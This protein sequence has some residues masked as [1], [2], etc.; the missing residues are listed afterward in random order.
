MTTSTTSQRNETGGTSAQLK[1]AYLQH[2]SNTLAKQLNLLSM[3][4]HNKIINTI[5]DTK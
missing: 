2:K 1:M 4:L 5:R 3:R